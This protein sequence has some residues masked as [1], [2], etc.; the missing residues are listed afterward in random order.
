MIGAKAGELDERIPFI[1][2][3]KKYTGLRNSSSE[4]KE[5]E[6]LIAESLDWDIQKINF[7]TFV[8]FYLAAGVVVPC[9][10]ISNNLLEFLA[11]KGIDDTVRMLVKEEVSVVR[12]KKL[13]EA[14]S[15]IDSGVIK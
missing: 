8:E 15:S 11:L 5:M 3:L 9:D 6:V 14:V 2:K 1:S 10:K 12:E 4:I 7:F 13:K